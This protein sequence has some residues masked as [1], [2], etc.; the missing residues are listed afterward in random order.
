MAFA[1][2]VMLVFDHC[3][4]CSFHFDQKATTQIVYRNHKSNNLNKK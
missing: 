4:N 2:F 1:G 3:I